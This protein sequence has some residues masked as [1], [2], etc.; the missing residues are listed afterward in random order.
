MTLIIDAMIPQL[1]A[2][3]PTADGRM[4]STGEENKRHKVVRMLAD[5]EDLSGQ[6]ETCTH[7]DQKQVGN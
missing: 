4:Q 6:S 7:I 1:P 3:F 5:A 2:P